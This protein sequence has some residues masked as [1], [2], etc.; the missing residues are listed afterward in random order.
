V[1]TGWDAIL[2]E[3]RNA[4]IPV[5][6][7]DRSVNSDPSLYAA[8]IGADMELEGKR[9]ADEM[10][11]LLPNGGSILELS[12]TTGSG[13]AVGLAKGFR[14]KLNATIKILDSRTGNFTRTEGKPVMEAFL[15]KYAG[16]FQGV[17]IHND[18][19]A[20]GVIEVIMAAGLK[21]GD[22]KI[23]SVDG[24]RP[25]FQAMVDGW[26]QADVAG[27]P[28]L[29]P[30]VLEMALKLMNGQPVDQE[31]LTDAT[32]YH[33]DDAMKLASQNCYRCY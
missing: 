11:K 23:V 12:G 15:K 5:I 1:E 20:L 18:E 4:N 31:V 28:L 9:A 7:M 14:E 33:L 8:H 30:Q 26:V 6:I 19:M 21:P 22:L 27:N 10:N 2:T 16:Q 3:A 17:F 25:G 29:G 13:A 32:V 24:T